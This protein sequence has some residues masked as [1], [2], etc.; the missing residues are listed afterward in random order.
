MVR[1][2]SVVVTGWGKGIDDPAVGYGQGAM[3]DEGGDD[4]D[5]TGCKEVLFA[6]NDHFQ[7]AFQDMGYLFVHV[8]VFR[9][10]TSL[11]DIPEPQRTAVAMDHFSEKARK[12]LLSGNIPEVLHALNF[13]EG[14]YK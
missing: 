2:L 7:L 14:T 13:P 1:F 4:V 8:G 10:N 9:Q 12:Q 5:G 6:A 11:P 3:G